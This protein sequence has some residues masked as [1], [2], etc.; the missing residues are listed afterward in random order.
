MK[1]FQLE[2]KIYLKR[3]IYF[4]DSFDVLSKFVSFSLCQIKDYEKLHNENRFKNYCFSTISPP[5][6]DRVY[7]KG[8]IYGFTI[9]AL[10]KKFIKKLANALREN[11]NNPHIQVLNTQFKKIKQFPIREIYSI[12]PCITTVDNQEGKQIFWTIKEDG[13]IVKLAKQLQDNLEKKYKAFYKKEL[14]AKQ[15]FIQLLAIKN[16]KPQ[17]IFFQKDA[18][19]IRFFGNKFQI[20]VNEDKVSQK[21]AFLALSCGLG[22]KQSYGGGFVNAKGIKW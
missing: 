5:Q 21:L 16:Q 7:K 4:L 15:N 22:E 19:K 14:K 17:S 18:R 8:T 13:D 2:C 11:I 20:V 9:R 3:D 6:K 1:F 12:S 10:D